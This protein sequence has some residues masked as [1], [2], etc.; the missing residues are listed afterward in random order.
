[1]PV[2]SRR[3]QVGR[4]LNALELHVENPRQR[5]DHQRLRQPR[6]ADQQAMPAGEDRGEDLLDHLVLPDDDLL[7]LL[8]ASAAGA[9]ELLQHIAQACASSSGASRALRDRGAIRR[10]QRVR[11]IQGSEFGGFARPLSRVA[12]DQWPQHNLP[13]CFHISIV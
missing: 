9:G 11:G 5:A 8:A 4:E 10:V 12:H 13:R 3:H 1:M 6:H 7:Q 2:M